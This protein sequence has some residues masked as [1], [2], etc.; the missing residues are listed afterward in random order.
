MI[1]GFVAGFPCT[2]QPEYVRGAD[3]IDRG[4]RVLGGERF[5]KSRYIRSYTTKVPGIRDTERVHVDG[6]GTKTK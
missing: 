4:I 2:E 3:L 1:P 5:E 6:C